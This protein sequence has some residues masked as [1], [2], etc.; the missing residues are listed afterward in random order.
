MQSP[1]QPGVYTA[2]ITDASGCEITEDYTVAEADPITATISFISPSC[3]GL[4]DGS[5][6][7]TTSG[8][9]QPYIYNWS[10]GANSASAV[11]LSANTYT[12]NV[13]DAN[14]CPASF[15]VTVTEP[16]QLIASVEATIFYNADENGNPYHISCF[17]L[18]DGA[19]IH[20]WE[21]LSQ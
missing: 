9:T 6:T 3:F 21:E 2:T 8:G 15:Y 18:S 11:G 10:N 1:L 4:S 19:A 14:Q 13:L 5:A 20:K 17:G 7:I 16:E 12:A